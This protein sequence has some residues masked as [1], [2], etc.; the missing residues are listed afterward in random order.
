MAKSSM[1]SRSFTRQAWLCVALLA[2]LCSLGCYN[3]NI[4]EGAF[5]CGA[6]NS[7]PDGFKCVD[8]RCFKSGSPGDGGPTDTGG[9]TDTRQCSPP[10]AGGSPVCDPVCQTGCPAANQCSNNGSTNLCRPASNPG[11]ALYDTCD[12][13]Q[14]SCRMGLVCLPEFTPEQCGAHCYRFCRADVDCGD[15]SR[16]VGEVA[17]ETGKP[18]YKTCSPRGGNCN[19]TGTNPRCADGAPA[20]RRFP[21]FACYI[22]S[23]NHAD[24][25]VCECAGDIPEG[26]PCERTYECVPG[27][28]CVPLGQDVRCRR[29]CT[30]VLSTLPMVACPVGQTCVAFPDTRKVGYCR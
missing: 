9:G 28:E 14:D 19:P 17:D 22:V 4:E 21:A 13:I 6:G 18:L 26:Q 2:P 27:N 12:P 8:M 30:P 20:D 7:C 1:S 5:L 25:T 29:L 11:A 24:E 16:C 10:P 23:P 15:G 3:P